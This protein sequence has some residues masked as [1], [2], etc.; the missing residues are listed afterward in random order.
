MQSQ[1]RI[2]DA[3]YFLALMWLIQ[4]LQYIKPELFQGMGIMPREQQGLW[5]IPLAPWLHHGFPHLLANSLPF[6]ILGS[7]I[8]FKSRMDFYM[9]TFFI[10]T[11]GG[12]GTWLF[13]SVGYHAGASGLVFGY[14]AWLVVNAVYCRSVKSF[15]LAMLVLFIYGGLFFSLLRVEQGVSWSGHAFGF[16][17]GVL[18]V[19]I[20]FKWK[21]KR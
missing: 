7:L 8:Q 2:P 18:A 6:L 4:L 11:I 21:S 5:H 20:K 13:G 14:W 9:A 10:I 1:W 12:L 3:F 17:G 15:L 19:V 16:L